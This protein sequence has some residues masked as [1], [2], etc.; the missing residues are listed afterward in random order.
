MAMSHSKHA[1]KASWFQ[2]TLESAKSSRETAVLASVPLLEVASAK[3][4]AIVNAVQVCLQ[5]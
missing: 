2:A 1:R 3:A 4:L 5:R